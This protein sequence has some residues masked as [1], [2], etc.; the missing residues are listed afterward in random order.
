MISSA[1]NYP[2]FFFFTPTPVVFFLQQLL[3][4]QYGY[5][6]FNLINGPTTITLTSVVPSP[7][8]AVNCESL[9]FTYFINLFRHLKY[10]L[11]L[12]SWSTK[13]IPKS[14]NLDYCVV[15]NHQ[16]CRLRRAWG[17][18]DSMNGHSRTWLVRMPLF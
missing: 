8:L 12:F 15:F 17:W 16:A 10:F 18:C 4:R 9:A 5:F 13:R 14:L 3:Q 11:L 7:T 1:W 2:F 6:V